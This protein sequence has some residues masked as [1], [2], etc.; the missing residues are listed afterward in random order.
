[1]KSYNISHTVQQQPLFVLQTFLVAGS[2][3]NAIVGQD[4]TV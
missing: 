4:D 2:R 3:L 1:M